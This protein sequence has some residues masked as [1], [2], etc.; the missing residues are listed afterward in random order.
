MEILYVPADFTLK[1]A[2]A[3]SNECETETTI[4]IET[5]NYN[6]ED[7]LSLNCIQ[8]YLII[9]TPVHIIGN[10][11]TI[12]GGI[13][14]PQK[15]KENIFIEDLNIFNDNGTGIIVKSSCQ[16]KN[17]TIQNC[18]DDGILIYGPYVH[19]ICTNIR[20]SNCKGNGIASENGA[21]VEIN[22]INTKFSKNL[23]GMA[24]CHSSTLNDSQI[25][26]EYPL[27]KEDISTNNKFNL[28][29][30]GNADLYQIQNI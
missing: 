14:I 29:A 26:I 16:L 27:T 24:V 25:N 13:F 22:G 19:C 2:I 8:N 21:I 1:E 3:R 7:R 12:N 20:V 4:F 11:S 28:N 17:I 15:I 18:E 10:N 5:N 30:I 23:C 6:I 9:K